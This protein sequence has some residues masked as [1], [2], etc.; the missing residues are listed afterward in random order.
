MFPLFL[1]LSGRLAVVIGG[2]S[3]GR[4]KA[5]A[6]LE[7][8][9]AVRL[10]CLEARPAELAQPALQWHAELYRIDHLDG[11]CLVC[12][13]ATPEVNRAVVADARGRGI[14]VNSA[15]DPDEGDFILPAVLRRDTLTL[16]V[17]TSG[18]APGLARNVRDLLAQQLDD[19]LGR[20]VALLAELRPVVLATIPDESRRRALFERLYQRDWL[21]RLRREGIEAVRAAMRA[22]IRVW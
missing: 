10:V 1:N 6:L 21:D 13:A 15:T 7:G 12:A 14:W 9:A 11:A 20:W 3:V 2:G 18:A 19:D 22:E 8:G 17:S 4:R 16:A 5:A